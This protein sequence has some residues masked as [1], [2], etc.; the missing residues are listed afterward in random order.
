MKEPLKFSMMSP[1]F[2]THIADREQRLAVTFENFRKP[3]YR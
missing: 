1:S 3:I 2:I